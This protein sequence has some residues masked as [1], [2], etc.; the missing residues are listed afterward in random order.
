MYPTFGSLTGEPPTLV[1]LNMTLASLAPW[2]EN[3]RGIDRAANVLT[4]IGTATNGGFA[5]CDERF[6]S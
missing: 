5:L 6:Q 4:A 3:R 1:T 2:R